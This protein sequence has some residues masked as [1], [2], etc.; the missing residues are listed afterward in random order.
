MNKGDKL[1][2]K[3]IYS[4]AVSV[5]FCICLPFLLPS[6]SLAGKPIRIG[7]Y[8]PMTGPVA[9]FGQMEWAGIQAAHQMR[10]TVLGRQVELVLVDEKSDRIEAA[11]AV[12]R[13]L[14]KEK[15]QAIIGSATSS[16]TMAGSA[17][18]EKA[19]IPMV[20][21]TATLPLVTQNKKYVFRVCFIDS[22][23]GEAAAMFAYRNLKARR[24]AV[25]VDRAQD[26][27]VGLASYFKKA[28]THLGGKIVSMAYCQTG[29]QDFS[30]Q[31]TSIPASQSDLLYLPNY[32]AEDALIA[33][34]ACELGLN[35]PILSADGAQAPEL[36]KIGGKAV[37]GLYLLAHFA[38]EGAAT[39][40]AKE[41]MEFFKKTR[42]EETSG[43]H[44]LG[45]DAYFVLLDAIKRAGRT[46]GDAIRTALASTRGFGGVSGII[47]IGPDGN[48]VKSAVILQVR[49]GQF[50]YLTIVKPW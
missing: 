4:V 25:I 28:F 22:F 37:E 1:Q 45:A 41:F 50:K 3:I 35:I 26:Y 48:A 19:K 14:K 15:I 5:F 7:V 11:N 27:C 31:L 8:L 10:P 47:K 44:A 40:L 49:G 6:L 20:S 13:L 21:P 30:A 16:N 39:P 24:V 29:D 34:Q 33:R 17:L 38:P 36:I 18:S 42:H 12:S 43:F 9:A 32:Y 2:H 46:D 23:Q